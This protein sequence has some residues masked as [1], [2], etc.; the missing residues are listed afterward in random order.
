MREAVIAPDLVRYVNNLRR[1]PRVESGRWSRIW[2]LY[3]DLFIFASMSQDL[4]QLLRGLRATA[5]PSRLR[6][7]ALLA[8]GEFTVS[9]LTGI[10]GQ[11]QPRVSRHLKLLSDDGLLER[12]REQHWVYYRLPA[13]GPGA[14]LERTLLGLLDRDDPLLAL[15]RE[16]AAAVIAARGAA[17]QG[18]GTESSSSVH[19]AAR[20]LADTIVA[21]LGR[22]G[23]DSVL[24]LGRAPAEMLKALGPQ[25]R[26]VVGISESRP[27]VQRARTSLHGRGLAHCAVQHGEFRKLP[28]A[29][30]SFDAVVLDRALAAR[31]TRP[32]GCVRPHECCGP[33]ASCSWSRITSARRARVRR[34]PAGHAAGLDCA[35]RAALHAAPSRGRRACSTCCSRSRR[36]KAPKRRPEH[37]TERGSDDG[38]K[39]IA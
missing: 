33:A 34:Q 4:H 24:Y 13:E 3:K 11:S 32:R 19:V 18:T 29:S 17:E 9:E 20:D 25:A 10:L 14:E 7:L 36:G 6:L 26:R 1:A 21:E 30:G 23:M 37:R 38:S 31:S 8:S 2:Q 22:N 28:A 16:R 5:E 35:G 15:D 12:F 27:E 39:C